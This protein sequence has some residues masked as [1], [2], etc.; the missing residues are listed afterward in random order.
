MR[1]VPMERARAIW[2]WVA[3]H[4]ILPNLRPEMG[5]ALARHRAQG[6]RIVL[7]SGT[8]Q[9]L[10]EVVASRVGAHGAVGTPL[11]QRDGRYLGRIVPPLAVGQG[12]AARLR[13]FAASHG[14]DLV[15]SYVY[16]DSFMDIPVL[17]LV[18]HPVAVHPDAR[19]RDVALGRAW[20][21]IEG[22]R[23]GV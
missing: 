23:K 18:G 3:N 12:K 6:G 8:F 16:T 22:P 2:F 7:L 4:Q 19:L 5:D 20:P 17:E 10:L 14:I 21:L 1:G 13:R 11:A 15:A 9:P